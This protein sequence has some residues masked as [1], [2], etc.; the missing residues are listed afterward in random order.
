MD[1]HFLANKIKKG[2]RCDA[3][4]NNICSGI[5]NGTGLLQCCK[6][7]CRNVLGDRN[8][9]GAGGHKCRFGQ[10]CW[11]GNCTDIAYNR[12]HCGKCDK[13]CSNGVKCEY[14]VSGYA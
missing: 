11:G 4:A 9:C 3:S 5:S 6:K 1:D 13:K 12:D 10:L 7:H 2:A 8:N 14:G